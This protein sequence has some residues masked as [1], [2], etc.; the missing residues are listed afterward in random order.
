MGNDIQAR[1]KLVLIVDEA[2]SI[3]FIISETLQLLG[4]EIDTA[5]N[6]EVA[7]Q[8]IESKN[9]DLIITDYTVPKINGL[10]LTRRINKIDPSLPIL[11]FAT[12]GLRDEFLES[13]ALACLK[14][15]F[16]IPEI[17]ILSQ[18]ILSDAC[19]PF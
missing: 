1:K 19:P 5:E 2:E 8:K 7:L 13:G 14:N 3:R 6:G 11:A 10:E 15:P 17:Q 9:Y 16:S 18:A 12:E 4:Y